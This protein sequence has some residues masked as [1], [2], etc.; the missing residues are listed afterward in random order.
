[1]LIRAALTKLEDQFVTC[2]R[3]FWK[4][5]PTLKCAIR[6]LT[7]TPSPLSKRLFNLLMSCVKL[8]QVP[9]LAS[10][11]S[12]NA[13]GAAGTWG[14]KNRVLKRWRNKTFFFCISGFLETSM[15]WVPHLAGT[16]STAQIWFSSVHGAPSTGCMN[17][18]LSQIEI[19]VNWP[20]PNWTTS[21]QKKWDSGRDSCGEALVPP[22]TE[23]CSPLPVW[24]FYHHE[25]R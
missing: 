21:H 23:A 13:P 20:G 10:H 3:G 8:R 1:M 2:T 4:M 11:S 17:Y 18:L 25:S 14:T 22:W 24:R 16:T 12:D 6:Q 9:P 19:S 15:S 7:Q 5:P